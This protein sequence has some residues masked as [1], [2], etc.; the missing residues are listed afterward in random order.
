MLPNSLVPK[1]LNSW[2][3]SDQL[4]SHFNLLSI[5]FFLS[6]RNENKTME[7]NQNK[8]NLFKSAISRKRAFLS[9]CKTAG[10]GGV[11]KLQFC[12]GELNTRALRT[13]HPPRWHDI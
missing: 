3:T 6:Q 10:G 1:R 2:G 8:I 7:K 13:G 9:R 12:E 11:L 4:Y 5:L